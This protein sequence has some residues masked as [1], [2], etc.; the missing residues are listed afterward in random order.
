MDVFN[1]ALRNPL[2]PLRRKLERRKLGDSD[3]LPTPQ[4][5]LRLD[6][7]N[8]NGKRK[9]N[10]RRK[11]RNSHLGCG[12][13]KKRRIKCDE[14]LPQCFN[15]VK[16]KLHC[17]Y[18]NLDA[19]AR[20]ALRMAQYNQNLRQDRHDDGTGKSSKDSELGDEVY[21]ESAHRGN[22]EAQ[23]YQNYGAYLIPLANGAQGPIG[24]LGSL[25][26]V[27][28]PIPGQTQQL[29]P[30]VTAPG[31]V[32]MPPGGPPTVVSGPGGAAYLQL[33]YAPIV[34]YQQVPGYAPVAVQ[35]VPGHPPPQVMY[36]TEQGPV[37]VALHPM[38]MAHPSMDGQPYVV[39]PNQERSGY[40]GGLPQAYSQVPMP[41]S[42]P[43]VSSMAGMAG[44][45]GAGAGAFPPGV[46]PSSVASSVAASA[47]GNVTSHP[48]AN[49][50]TLATPAMENAVS[51][52]PATSNAPGPVVP[53]SPASRDV[54]PP[55]NALSN[56]ALLKTSPQ[57]P[58]I[59][60]ALLTHLAEVKQEEPRL[61]PIKA[62]LALSSSHPSPEVADKVPS[63]LK[64]LS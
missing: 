43:A 56:P 49:P 9:K 58:V 34:Q 64:L 51:S 37:Q 30:L 54:L 53:A 32:V 47:S 44:P 17:A 22:V 39:V 25:N 31:Q 62:G 13:C 36:Q 24:A 21:R 57:L 18:L 5:D 27:V 35:V 28:A 1:S 46:M 38:H 50:A 26:S 15:C 63:I 29:P 7:D 16:G 59:R 11:H 52:T 3:S 12:T 33:P 14:N 48:G 45:Y 23:Y 8:G 42:V 40:E 6:D 4:L 20:N 55:I 61:P 41:L 2:P 19:P 10:S 60:S